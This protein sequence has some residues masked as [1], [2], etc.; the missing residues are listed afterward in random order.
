MKYAKPFYVWY[1]AK[2]THA[3]KGIFNNSFLGKDNIDNTVYTTTVELTPNASKV[4]VVSRLSI[5]GIRMI[6]PS[7]AESCLVLSERVEGELE[8]SLN[9]LVTKLKV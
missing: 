7:F 4:I 8:S 6:T 1:K 2:L 9:D 5:S 3:A